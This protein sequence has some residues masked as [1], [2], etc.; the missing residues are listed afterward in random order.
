MDERKLGNPPLYCTI[1]V[2]MEKNDF[3]DLVVEKGYGRKL[4][5]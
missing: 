1:L 5:I 4:L 3:V 2:L